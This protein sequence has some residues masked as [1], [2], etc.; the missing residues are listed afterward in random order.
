MRHA[1]DATT[2]AVRHGA[3]RLDVTVTDDG[4]GGTRLPAEA[5]GGGFGL[6]GLRERVTALGGTL[7]TGPRPTSPGRRVRASLPTNGR[8][9]RG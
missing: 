1:A 4:R 8:A 7:D 3:G 5:H 6:V 2:V 9:R